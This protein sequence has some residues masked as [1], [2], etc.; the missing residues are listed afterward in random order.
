MP[1]YPPYLARKQ[2]F[3]T[4]IDH[5]KKRVGRYNWLTGTPSRTHPEQ[6][7]GNHARG[8]AACSIYDCWGEH[9]RDLAE[10]PEDAAEDPWNQHVIFGE[11]VQAGCGM[12]QEARDEI[13]QPAYLP[14]K[15]CQMIWKRPIA[16][17]ELPAE[18]IEDAPTPL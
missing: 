7:H 16:A 10:A 1:I 5:L 15:N 8:N 6:V 13:P 3:R 12:P 14:Q 17:E 2:I 11:R 18:D 9:L 4:Q